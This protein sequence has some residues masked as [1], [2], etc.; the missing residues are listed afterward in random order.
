M[1]QENKIGIVD[2]TAK[3][4]MTGEVRAANF[5]YAMTREKL[6]SGTVPQENM[7]GVSEKGDIQVASADDL[8]A[9]ITYKMCGEDGIQ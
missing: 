9:V 3:A 6:L 4:G 8:Y 7:M 1:P 2:E 5:R